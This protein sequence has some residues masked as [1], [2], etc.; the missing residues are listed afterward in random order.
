MD[1]RVGIFNPPY[2]LL[3]DVCDQQSAAFLRVAAMAPRVRFA[4]TAV[5]AL[6]DD[7]HRVDITVENAGYLPT[8]VLS[9]ARKLS[10]NEPL[11]LELECDGCELAEGHTRRV[12]GHLDGWGRGLGDG[13]AALYY[14]Y[15]RG[16][17]GTAQESVVVRGSGRVTATVRSCRIGAVRR[18]IELA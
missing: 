16:N 5:E 8:Y 4:Q 2:E 3:P 15:G 18:T 12:L 10:W 11:Y 6:G 9:S 17:T 1:Q 14:P 13:T 7:V